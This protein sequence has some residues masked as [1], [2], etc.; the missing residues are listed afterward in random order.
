[1]PAALGNKSL[2]NWNECGECNEKVF[3]V[4]K[5][6][7][8]N[9]LQSKRILIRGKPRKGSPKYKLSKDNSFITSTPGT[10]L[11]TISLDEE[12]SVLELLEEENNILKLKCNNMP[13]YSL[14]GVCKAFIFASEPF[15]VTV[16][17]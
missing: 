6:E 15:R 17:L 4:H 8:L 10:N 12:E 1:M 16:F 11:V 14:S 3:S 5:N 9:Y 13:P 7:L 2:F